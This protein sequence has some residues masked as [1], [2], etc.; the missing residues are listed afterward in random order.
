MS[1]RSRS[2]PRQSAERRGTATVETALVLPLLL[3]FFFGI[4]EYGQY[5]SVQQVIENAARS[6]ARYAVVNTSTATTAQ[7]QSYVSGKLSTVN[8]WI[9]PTISV[10]QA[11][12]VTGNNLGPWTSAGFGKSIAVQIR[13]TYS[14]YCAAFVKMPAQLTMQ[15][16]AIMT[17]E[18]N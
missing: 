11:D 9:S 12:P 18:A 15:T 16:Q 7:V 10:Y 1:N 4:F 8:N 5:L 14:P 6:G 13:G 2:T 17:S 3:L